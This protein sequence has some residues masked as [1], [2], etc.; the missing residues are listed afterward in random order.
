MTYIRVPGPGEDPFGHLGP[1]FVRLDEE[2]ARRTLGTVLWTLDPWL[3][4]MNWDEGPQRVRHLT[5]I[6]CPAY[7]RL[8]HFLL[9][10]RRGEQE[11][12][13]WPWSRLLGDRAS[14]LGPDTR[15][16]EV[17]WECRDMIAREGLHVEPRVGE[18]V[19]DIARALARVLA[20]HGGE[21]TCF[22]YYPSGLG[23]LP[24]RGTHVYRGPIRRVDTLRSTDGTFFWP[25]LW[26]PE[27]ESW[28]VAT[29]TDATSTYVG[30][31]RP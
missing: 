10:S 23:F 8:L 21:P 19:E 28:F 26:W 2:T 9:V 5:L 7:A 20:E 17:V 11:A 31:R 14:M 27:D 16:R 4:P 18:I 30:V 29:H 13:S 1:T 6:R 3:F 22:F 12:E 25:T 24:D 15:L